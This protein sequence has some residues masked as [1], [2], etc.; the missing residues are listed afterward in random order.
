[1]PPPQKI[2]QMKMA[3]SDALWYTVIVPATEG[4]A[5]HVQAL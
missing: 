3:C 4:R 5:P 1:M 2:S